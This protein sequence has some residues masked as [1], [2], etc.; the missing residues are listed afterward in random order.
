MIFVHS[1]GVEKCFFF[2]FFLGFVCSEEE[3]ASSEGLGCEEQREATFCF[4]A[5]SV[6]SSIQ[7][8]ISNI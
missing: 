8:W 3:D 6:A 7:I 2:H 1:Q 5:D 4:F